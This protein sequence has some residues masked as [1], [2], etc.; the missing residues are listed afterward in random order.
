M[1]TVV[2]VSTKVTPAAGRRQWCVPKPGADEMML[3]ENID[4]ACGQEGVDCA[5]IRPGGGA[6][7]R[8]FMRLQSITSQ[9]ALVPVARAAVPVARAQ[10]A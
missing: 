4:F 10:R 2:P 7:I 8:R 5:A 1:Q 3:Q 6:S 9:K